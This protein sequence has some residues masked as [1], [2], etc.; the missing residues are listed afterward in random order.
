MRVVLDDDL[1]EKYQAMAPGKP[2]APVLE[3]QL[4]RFVQHP[5][6]TRLVVLAREQLEEVESRLGGGQI[7]SAT[8]LIARVRDFSTVTFEGVEIPL[9][10]PQKAELVV[11]AEKQGKTVEALV[12]DLVGQLA[13]GLFYNTVPTR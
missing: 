8:A 5:P 12:K 3:K 7:Q 1:M 2:L 4:A 13:D 6:G 11:R 10:A 9:T